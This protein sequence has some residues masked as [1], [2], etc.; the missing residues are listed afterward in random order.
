[1]QITGESTFDVPS[2]E[3][4]D[5]LMNP[6]VMAAT[7]PGAEKLELV[8]ENQY[9]STLNIKVGPVQGQFRGRIQLEDIDPPNS[10]TIKVDGQ[11]PQGFVRATARIVIASA[12]EKTQITYDGNAVVG[13]RIASVGQRL[14]ES[15]ARAIIRQSLEGLNATLKA[16][17][18]TPTSSAKSPVVP[19]QAAPSQTEFAARVTKEVATEL[20]PTSVWIGGGILVL[21]LLL[22]LIL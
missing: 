20:V 12:E 16:R 11:G 19:G 9:E 8:G 15:S 5:G 10:Y 21:L 6:E 18:T 3:V 14:M 1:M 17:H 13:G 2:D 7:M 4:W 22:Y